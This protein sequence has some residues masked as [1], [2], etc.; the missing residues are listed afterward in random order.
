MRD[1]EF[2]EGVDSAGL[3]RLDHFGHH[4]A[5]VIVA[6]SGSASQEL[7]S[8]GRGL[9]LRP[10]D[11]EG[12]GGAGRRGRRADDL[13]AE[14]EALVGH[15]GRNERRGFGETVVGRVG[16]LGREVANL[17]TGQGGFRGRSHV[18]V[19]RALGPDCPV[20]KDR[21]FDHGWIKQHRIEPAE[22]GR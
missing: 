8:A 15:G 4:L 14:R 3:T 11:P 2:Q 19:A 10:E 18:D 6:V 16:D 5:A 20:G 1:E 22:I 7:E 12:E 9:H 21:H 17:L 13:G